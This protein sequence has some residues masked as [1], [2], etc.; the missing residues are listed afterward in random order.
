MRGRAD[1]RADHMYPNVLPG[2]ACLQRGMSASWT[3]G[4]RLVQRR[5]TMSND[6]AFCEKCNAL[7]GVVK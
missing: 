4:A 3:P 6:I 2:H 1:H 7:D 5:P